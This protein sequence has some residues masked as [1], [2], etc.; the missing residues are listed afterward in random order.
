M[1]LTASNTENGNGD[2]QATVD[3][4]AQ[5]HRIALVLDPSLDRGAVGNRCAVLSTGLASRHPEIIGED[6]ITADHL[7]LP[8]FTKVPMAVLMTKEQS[9]REIANRAR[10]RNCTTLVFLARAQGMR[11]YE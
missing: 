4:L 3:Q 10:E 1:N 5:T 9:L 8:G 7:S 11:S 2:A 6:L